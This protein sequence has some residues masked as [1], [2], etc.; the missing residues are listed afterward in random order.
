MSTKNIEKIFNPESIVLIGASEKKGSVGY[1]LFKN[2]LDG[3]F[4][5]KVYGVNPK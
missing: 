4:R 2:L 5:G 1:G 3:G